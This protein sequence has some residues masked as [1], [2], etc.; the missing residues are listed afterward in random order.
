[1]NGPVATCWTSN[2]GVGDSIPRCT[3]A[4]LTNSLSDVVTEVTRSF[5]KSNTLFVQMSSADVLIRYLCRSHMY[6]YVTL[7]QKFY[8]TGHKV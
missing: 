2:P 1:M 5:D 7:A 8:H 3:L 4:N 6:V